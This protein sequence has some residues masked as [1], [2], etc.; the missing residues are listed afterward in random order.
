MVKQYIE[1][2]KYSECQLVSVLNARMCLTGEYLSP[3]SKLYEDLVD[4]TGAR[5]GAAISICYALSLF[6][7]GLKGG[8]ATYRW[9]EKNLPVEVSVSH[10]KVG[11]H[12]VCIVGA[13]NH[14]V[15][16]TNAQSIFGKRKW[17]EWKELQKYLLKRRNVGWNCEC[18][19]LF[20]TYIE[21]LAVVSKGMLHY[22]AVEAI[23][24]WQKISD[25]ECVLKKKRAYK[26]IAEAHK[27]YAKLIVKQ[28][29]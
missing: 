7:M 29:R 2:Q 22:R 20:M 12:C 5:Y 15:R 3:D 28:A 6:N 13:K 27:R 14:K 16:V 9:I 19:S 26:K 1:S 4:V 11:L 8:P 24:Y 17:I 21:D 23:E 10:E 18:E 25:K